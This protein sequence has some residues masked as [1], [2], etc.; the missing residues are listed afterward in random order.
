MTLPSSDQLN[1]ELLA[2][3]KA[4]F[5]DPELLQ[6]IAGLGNQS[7]LDRL[8]A[9]ANVVQGTGRPMLRIRSGKL[10]PPDGFWADALSPSSATASRL[11]QAARS[12]GRLDLK[13]GN[14]HGVQAGTAW[15]VRERVAVTARHVVLS[16]FGMRTSSQS[17]RLRRYVDGTEYHVTLDFRAAPEEQQGTQMRVTSILYLGPKNGPDLALLRVEPSGTGP[18]PPMEI[19]SAAAFHERQAIAVV[20]FPTGDP[21][22]DLDDALIADRPGTKRVSPGE[23]IRLRPGGFAHDASTTQSSSGS[24]VLDIDSGRVIGMHHGGD[25]TDPSTGFRAINFALGSNLIE[26]TLESHGG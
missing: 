2:E 9:V 25:W 11:V 15:L 14:G 20:G 23:V 10:D 4:S 8:F 24:P 5:D 6:S 18:G 12:V 19:E 22:D 13:L 7:F 3:L 1:M 21:Y 26:A 17:G 16:K